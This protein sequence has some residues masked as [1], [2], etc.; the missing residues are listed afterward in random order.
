MHVNFVNEGLRRGLAAHCCHLTSKRKGLLR[1]GCG[2]P[3]QVALW[4]L[5]A[6][7]LTYGRSGQV[8]GR[9]DTK[10]SDW[11]GGRADSNRLTFHLIPAPFSQADP[12]YI[13]KTGSI[14]SVF[15]LELLSVCDGFAG[16]EPTIRTRT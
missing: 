12:W 6:I 5:P 13:K 2:P 16:A 15:E 4:Q 3:I 10:R 7:N 11:R 8:C 9:H 14:A 1:S